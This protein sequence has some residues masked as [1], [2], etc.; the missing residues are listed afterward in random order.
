MAN[1]GLPC[2]YRAKNS[3]FSPCFV[4]QTPSLAA[5]R[6]CEFLQGRECECRQESDGDGATNDPMGRQLHTGTR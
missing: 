6:I 1:T 3:P 5:C 4:F 2:L